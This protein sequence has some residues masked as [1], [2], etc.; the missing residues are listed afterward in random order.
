MDEKTLFA[1]G[2]NTRASEVGITE[3]GGKLSIRFSRTPLLEGDLDHW[4]YDTFIA[5]WR[6]R[7]LRADAYVTFAL[8]PAGRWIK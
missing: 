4:Q 8:S 3:A 7:E 2:S 6:D 5:R 1:I